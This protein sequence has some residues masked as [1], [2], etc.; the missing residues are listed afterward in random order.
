MIR[1]EAATPTGTAHLYEKDSSRDEG[2]DK[3]AD[4]RGERNEEGS[5]RNAREV[6]G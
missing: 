4:G 2:I 6:V 3:E 1:K 5:E